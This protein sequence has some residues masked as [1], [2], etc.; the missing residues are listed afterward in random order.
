MVV[1][2]LIFNRLGDKEPSLLDRGTLVTNGLRVV[3]R[4]L[5]DEEFGDFIVHLE[6]L[7]IVSAI[8][9]LFL[10]KGSANSTI[11]IKEKSCILFMVLGHLV[12]E[13]SDLFFI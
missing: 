2:G 6:I 11:K 12:V 3:A 9:S 5:P 1:K 13:I 10:L 7:I 4:F 8:L